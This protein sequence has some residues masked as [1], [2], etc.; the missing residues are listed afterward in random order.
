MR[1]RLA[2]RPA[3]LTGSGWY[4]GG[5]HPKNEVVEAAAVR[6]LHYL[7]DERFGTREALKLWRTRITLLE[8][9]I[10]RERELLGEVPAG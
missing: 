5:P 8:G 9:V 4:L 6:T 1:L 7:R 2:G 3:G 10:H